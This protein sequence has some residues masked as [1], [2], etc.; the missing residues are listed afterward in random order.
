[1]TKCD[2]C[3]LLFCDIISPDCRLSPREVPKI[4]PDLIRRL[5]ASQ[6]HYR[7]YRANYISASRSWRQRNPEHYRKIK[8]DQWAKNKDG[9]NARRREKRRA[10]KMAESIVLASI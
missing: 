1:M 5:T 7:R 4:R 8:R 3:T 6:E 9:I 10:E 2:N